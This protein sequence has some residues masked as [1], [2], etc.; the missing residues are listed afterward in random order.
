MSANLP[1]MVVHFRRIYLT[2]KWKA[3]TCM[4]RAPGCNKKK[5]IHQVHSCWVRY[6]PGLKNLVY[7]V[8]FLNFKFGTRMHTHT[9]TWDVTQ[10]VEYLIFAK[11]PCNCNAPCPTQAPP[12]R[13][14]WNF[15]WR[16]IGM[17][18]KHGGSCWGGA[19]QKP[20]D[21]V[22]LE[23]VVQQHLATASGR[24]GHDALD[25]WAALGQCWRAPSRPPF[26]QQ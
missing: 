5:G 23:L 20:V 7:D 15:W 22:G 24:L 21:Q 19:D 2:G 13:P 11:Y 3:Y 16:R 4:H 1:R 18:T 8:Q 26:L 10:R 14:W 25:G 17:A 6:I 9:C 12:H